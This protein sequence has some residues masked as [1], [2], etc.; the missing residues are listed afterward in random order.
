MSS[1]GKDVWEL[2][3]LKRES[4][5]LLEDY[6]VVGEDVTVGEEAESDDVEAEE[7]KEIDTEEAPQFNRK[8]KVCMQLHLEL[9]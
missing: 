2:K 3:P 9:A 8:Q 5:D 7:M 1:G 4:S 6:V